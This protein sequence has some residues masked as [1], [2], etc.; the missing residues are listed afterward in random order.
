MLMLI[1]LW[2]VWRRSRKK[3]NDDDPV[4]CKGK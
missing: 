4:S 2:G 3:V 1:V